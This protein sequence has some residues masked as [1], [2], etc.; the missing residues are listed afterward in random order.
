MVVIDC[1]ARYKGYCSDITRTWAGGRLAPWQKEIYRVVRR[2]QIA[3]IK[4][5]SPGKTG[6]EVDR[7]AREVIAAAGYGDYFGHGLGHGVGLAVHEAPRLSPR[8]TGPL[9]E[10][11]V[12]TVEPGIYLPGRGGVRLE[13]LVHVTG[14][15]AKVLNRDASFYDF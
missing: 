3:A 12:V 2:A 5:M 1:G 6:A 14:D 8:A 7:A 4:A 10:G 15:G 11:A 9:P 13:Q